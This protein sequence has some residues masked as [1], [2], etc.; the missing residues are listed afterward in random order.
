MRNARGQF[1]KGYKHPNAKPTLC[2][3]NE[4][5]VTYFRKPSRAKTTRFC[6]RKCCAKWVYYNRNLE[7]FIRGKA[8]ENN[9]AWRGGVSIK[10]GYTFIKVGRRKYKQEHR[11]VMEKL[12]GREL[13]RREVVHHI[14]GNRADNRPE[15]LTIMSQSEHV[16][17]HSPEVMG[18]AGRKAWLEKRVDRPCVLCGLMFTPNSAPSKYCSKHTLS[19]K[20]GEKNL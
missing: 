18:L 8:D 4:C 14:N 15:N 6:S 5:G 20:Y 2:V 3:C 7:Q 9:P 13:G 12:L 16:R 1:N 17:T 11:I 19:E 10:C